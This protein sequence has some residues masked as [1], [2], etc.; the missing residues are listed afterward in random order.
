MN[1]KTIST[2][3][4]LGFNIIRANLTKERRPIFLSL[5]ITNRCNLRCRY[6]FVVDERIPKEILCSEYSK[7][8]IF[9]MVDEFYSMGTRMI[10]MLG[11]EPLLHKD[12]KAIIDYI[13]NKGIYLH[14]ITN[15][16]LIQRKL[17][18]IKNVH[19]LCVSLDGVGIQ[20]DE[21]RGEGTFLKVVEGIR[22]SVSK[23]IPTRIHAVVTRR[24]INDIKS[25]AELAR[26]LKVKLT[27]SPP[28]FLGETDHEYLRI[29][30][31]EYKKFWSE[32][33]ELYKKGYPIGNVP[34]A[35]KKCQE[36]PADYHQYIKTDEVFKGYKPTFCLNGY[37]YV[38]VGAEG[39]MYNCINR[40]CLNG[41]SIKELGIRKAWEI[42]L[43]WRKDCVSCSSINCIE[44]AM[45][46]NMSIHSLLSGAEFHLARSK[47]NKAHINN[48]REMGVKN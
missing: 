24:N 4:D 28:N 31:D 17:D 1:L 40:G 25:L 18:D 42:L 8:E 14:V 13:V 32:Y 27:V 21:L 15:G 26:D 7:E 37:T 41:P 46:L 33:L 5:F 16:T 11:G 9:K 2:I 30:K 45:M 38:A 29:S 20:N 34:S 35:I 48:S 36:W 19:A 12:I 47:G 43:D 10:F 44:T 3:A 6:C 22:A 39:T 23:G